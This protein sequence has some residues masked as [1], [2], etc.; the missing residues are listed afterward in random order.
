MG[1]NFNITRGRQGV[2]KSRDRESV[3]PGYAWIVSHIFSG[4]L[5]FRVLLAC[6]Y[7]YSTSATW[8]VD[9][10]SRQ[11]PVVLGGYTHS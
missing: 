5:F 9:Q 3:W 6:Y 4:S 10:F 11:L 7:K 1:G 8:V 2:S